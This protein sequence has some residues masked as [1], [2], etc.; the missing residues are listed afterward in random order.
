MKY[1]CVAIPQNYEVTIYTDFR[2][3]SLLDSGLKIIF[4]ER[5]VINK[6]K[7]L[8]NYI[9]NK[10]PICMMTDDVNGFDILADPLNVINV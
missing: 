7:N 4:V 5:I 8:L 10:V 1:P 2:P 3:I 6:G 9:V